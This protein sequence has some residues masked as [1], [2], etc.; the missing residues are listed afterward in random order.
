MKYL[1]PLFTFVFV[2][3]I[4]SCGGSKKKDM[5]I[6]ADEELRQLAER[7]ENAYAEEK[8]EKLKALGGVDSLALIAWGDTRFGMTKKEVI[9]SEAFKREKE[10]VEA[11]LDMDYGDYY[12][13]G[14]KKG[15]RLSK[16]Y[17]L[18]TFP[19][20]KA[21]FK[22][23]ELYLITIETYGRNADKIEDLANDCGIFAK[24]FMKKYGEPDF[25]RTSVSILDF[26]NHQLN[27]ATFNIGAKKIWIGLLEDDSKYKYYISIEN[28]TF[29][30]KKH[31]PTEQELK[32]MKEQEEK[33]RE[34]KE[35]SF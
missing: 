29:P 6:E 20:I 27:I 3:L 24:E 35:N 30:K 2:L 1:F 25:L 13:T 23:D 17:G 7:R 28:K 33:N 8:E 18:Y 19:E 31:V 34:L 32:Q 11:K 4:C 15:S 16:L 22:E 9:N 14:P 21:H 12:T 10:E 5:S 26:S